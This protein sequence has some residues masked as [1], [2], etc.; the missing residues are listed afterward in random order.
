MEPDDVTQELVTLERAGW[1]ALCAGTGDRFYADLMTNDG[2][3]VLVDGSVLDRDG[4]AASLAGAP[5]WSSYAIADLRSLPLGP[6]ARALVYTGRA[7]RDGA[8]APFVAAMC[9]VYRREADRWRLAL[10]QQTAQPQA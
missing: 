7:H 4:V 1:D 8:P 10:Y 9:S 6:D 5:P 2:L 3:M